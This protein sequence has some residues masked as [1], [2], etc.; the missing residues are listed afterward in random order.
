[1]SDSENSDKPGL[2]LQPRC[3]VGGL[4]KLAVYDD[5]PL[6]ETCRAKANPTVTWTVAVLALL[7]VSRLS[8]L[9]AAPALI[10]SRYG[11]GYA[12]VD[13]HDLQQAP[14]NIEQSKTWT[15]AYVLSTPYISKKFHNSPLQPRA[16]QWRTI[17]PR[18]TLRILTRRRFSS[19]KHRFKPKTKK[20]GLLCT[21][22]KS[23]SL[24]TRS[25]AAS[26]KPWPESPSPKHHD[27]SR[28]PICLSG[29]RCWG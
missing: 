3:G 8:G 18:A 24:L 5:G 22:V 25:P 26:K 11:R 10:S 7:S 12:Q 27:R 29:G 13:P 14:K 9:V 21:A 6:R 1:M 23:I 19:F 15:R 28:E 17:T 16:H 2:R 4:D 20:S